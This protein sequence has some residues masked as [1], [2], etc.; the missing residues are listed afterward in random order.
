MHTWSIPSG[1]VPRQGGPVERA[2]LFTMKA[3]S[4]AMLYCFRRSTSTA[5]ATTTTALT[6][7]RGRY[8]IRH[9]TS[10]FC[11]SSSRSTH[12]RTPTPEHDRLRRH[13]STRPCSTWGNTM[14]FLGAS[15]PTSTRGDEPTSTRASTASTRGLQC[16][17][18][19]KISHPS[20][21][22]GESF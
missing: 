1:W 8:R 12:S 13:G 18:H 10:V 14:V 6:I 19:T 4:S 5:I 9:G 7:L 20:L 17:S 11:S 3:L 15:S 16:S 2:A 22:L 21:G